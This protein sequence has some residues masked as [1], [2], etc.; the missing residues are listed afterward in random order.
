ME[1]KQRR[2]MLGDVDPVVPARIE[3]KFVGNVARAEDFVE[4]RSA[5]LKAE[6]VFRAA[7]KIDFQC[8]EIGGARDGQRVVSFPEK[9]IERRAED[10][11]EDAR[12]GGLARIGNGNGRKFLEQGGAVGSHGGEQLGMAKAEMQ[13]AVPAHGNSGNAAGSAPGLRA[14]AFFDLG[15]KFLE[16]KILVTK[17][18]IA[19]VD[20][21]AGASIRRDDEEITELMPLPE[22]L[23]KIEAAGMNEHLLVVAEAVKKIENGIAARLF[24]VVAGRQKDAVSDGVAEDFAGSGKTFGADGGAKGLRSGEAAEEQNSRCDAAE[25]IHSGGPRRD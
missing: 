22:V 19:R 13:R 12:P 14:I 10:I 7:V 25:I 23:D 4:R 3:M 1:L 8:R 21:E 17:A 9:R 15:K 5:V 2:Q 24:R 16:E 20:V 18:A 11:A 6:I